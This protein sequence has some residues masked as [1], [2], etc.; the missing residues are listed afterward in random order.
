MRCGCR[1]GDSGWISE[2][3]CR[4][5]VAEAVEHRFDWDKSVMYRIERSVWRFIE[6]GRIVAG[7]GRAL[8]FAQVLDTRVSGQMIRRT[9]RMV[10]LALLHF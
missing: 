2:A 7:P 6:P 1:C 5:D 3:I 4:L 10:D 8:G 9:E